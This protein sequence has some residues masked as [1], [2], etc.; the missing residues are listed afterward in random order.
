MEYRTNVHATKLGWIWLWEMTYAIY[1]K[2]LPSKG[3]PSII[4]FWSISWSIMIIEVTVSNFNW[5]KC[6]WVWRATWAFD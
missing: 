3:S 6:R 2:N 4:I 5:Q 1:D